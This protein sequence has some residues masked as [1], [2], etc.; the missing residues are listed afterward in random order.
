MVG[1]DRW[2][3]ARTSSVRSARWNG[4]PTLARTSFSAP[5][6]HIVVSTDGYFD[7]YPTSTRTNGDK[8]AYRGRLAEL[9]AGIRGAD[10][11]LAVRPS[12][13]ALAEAVDG[14]GRGQR[15]RRPRRHARRRPRRQRRSR[16]KRRKVVYP[17]ARTHTK[18][19]PKPGAGPEVVMV[20]PNL[21]T[22]N[23][24]AGAGRANLKVGGRVRISG[25]R[26][27]RR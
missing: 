26:A 6:A 18:G 2:R 10:D 8:P 23:L 20:R 19:A 24:A 17:V 3:R 14:L 9:G 21:A 1:C 12:S 22:I 7:V 11:R 5:E 27:V 4:S 13:P 15:R 16:V 25:I